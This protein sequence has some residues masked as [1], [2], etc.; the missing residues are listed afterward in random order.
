MDSAAIIDENSWSLVSDIHT[1][2]VIVDPSLNWE[3]W[4]AM[5]C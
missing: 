2:N 4:D 5:R 3:T 1:F